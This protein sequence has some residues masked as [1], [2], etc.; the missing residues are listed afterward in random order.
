MIGTW[1]IDEEEVKAKDFAIEHLGVCYTHFMYD[2][3]KLYSSNLKQ[4]KQYTESI[5]HHCRCLFCNKY[6]FFL[7]V[8]L[9]VKNTHIQL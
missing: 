5:I 7:V 9:T 6:K 8:I 1:Q 2:Q 4:T 3:N